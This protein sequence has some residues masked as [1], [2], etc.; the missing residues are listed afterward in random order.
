MPL[1]LY[2]YSY[3]T[4]SGNSLFFSN[5]IEQL[6]FHLILSHVSSHKISS[7]TLPHMNFFTLPHTLQI[8]TCS[9]NS[10]LKSTYI[11]TTLS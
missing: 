9:P 8:L 11:N 5:R 2:G 3:L 7:T 4:K 6:I 10:N 1:Q